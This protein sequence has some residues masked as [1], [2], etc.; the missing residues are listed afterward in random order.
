MRLK[1]IKIL[2][3]SCVLLFNPVSAAK[4]SSNMTDLDQSI[5]YENDNS[6]MGSEETTYYNPYK[7]EVV[8]EGKGVS[9]YGP[10]QDIGMTKKQ[11][12]E[13]YSSMEDSNEK[14]K[15]DEEEKMKNEKKLEINRYRLLTIG[16][17]SITLVTIVLMITILTKYFNRK[18][19]KKTESKDKEYDE[20]LNNVDYENEMQKNIEFDFNTYLNNR[21]EP[22]SD[23]DD[24]KSFGD[25]KSFN[26][27]G[28]DEN[29]DFDYQKY[30]NGDD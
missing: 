16:I 13:F 24:N 6:G 7:Q 11:I 22:Y 15:K 21:S 20:L 27:D 2:G 28:E 4:D 10:K 19:L 23:I 29:I 17:I 8:E 12:E 18:E 26:N 5:K 3:L 30:I 9:K 1:L 14:L 25:N